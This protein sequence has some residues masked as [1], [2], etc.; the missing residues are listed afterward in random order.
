MVHAALA[1]HGVL[2]GAR[3][4]DSSRDLQDFQGHDVAVF[5]VVEDHPGLVFVAF[6]D[7]RIAQQD[8]QYV[9]F[10]IVCYLHGLFQYFSIF[11]VPQTVTTTAGST[12][13]ST[14]N[15]RRNILPPISRLDWRASKAAPQC[16]GR[17]VRRARPGCELEIQDVRM[18]GGASVLPGYPIQL[19]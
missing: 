17:V 19:R 5:V 14:M 15:L 4:G 10:G 7:G 1:R 18:G 13:S 11:V 3:V 8:S 12:P 16:R 2:D 6:L 9:H